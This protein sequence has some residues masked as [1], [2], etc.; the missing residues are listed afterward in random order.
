VNDCGRQ[1]VDSDYNFDIYVGANLSTS[2][3]YTSTDPTIEYCD[4]STIEDVWLKQYC[5]CYY[6]DTSRSA[7][8]TSW[9]GI[10]RYYNCQNFRQLV[11]CENDDWYKVR[12]SGFVISCIFIALICGFCCSFCGGGGGGG[13]GT[14]SEYSGYVTEYIHVVIPVVRRS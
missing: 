8:I 12:Y 10:D 2:D 7:V 1:I 11:G 6:Y 5:Y 14:V 13:G 4:V 3:N 9:E